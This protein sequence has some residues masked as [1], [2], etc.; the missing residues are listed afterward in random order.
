MAHFPFTIVNTNTAVRARWTHKRP[1]SNGAKCAQM[2]FVENKWQSLLQLSVQ[3]KWRINSFSAVEMLLGCPLLSYPEHYDRRTLTAENEFIFDPWILLFFSRGIVTMKNQTC[4]DSFRC[5]NKRPT[6]HVIWPHIASY[7]SRCSW[8]EN[9][10]QF[11]AI[12]IWFSLQFRNST[13]TVSVQLTWPVRRNLFIFS[14][15]ANHFTSDCFEFLLKLISPESGWHR[16]KP[17]KTEKKK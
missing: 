7:A 13:W 1:V 10:R 5:L 3:K 4:D 9:S 6:L 17:S 2:V 12:R 14:S 8:E 15:H 11:A 16:S